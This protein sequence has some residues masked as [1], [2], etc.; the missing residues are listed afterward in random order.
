MLQPD[1]IA[2]FRASGCRILEQAPMKD[3]TTFHIGGPA[4]YFIT[5]PDEQAAGRVMAACR[6]QK[7]P[8][9]LVG[10]G[11]NLLVSDEGIDGVVL[12]L[13]G[14]S[15]P[16]DCDVASGRVTAYGGTSLAK[17]C[18]TARDYGLT[19][20]EFA[21]GIPGTVGGSVYMNAGAYGG[22]VAD[23]L[24]SATLLSPDGVLRTMK[25]EDLQ[26]GY[27]H[28]LLMETGEIAVGAV[29][30]LSPG[31]PEHIG[32]RM[33]ELMNKRREKQPLE[34]PSA[35]SFFKRPEGHFAAAL[36][37]QCRLK[38]FSVGDA[39]VSEKHAGFV[40]N[41]GEATCQDMIRLK[42]EVCRRVYEQTGVELK[43]EVELTGR[44]VR[45]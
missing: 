44:N 16:T 4:D 5:A 21:F 15:R 33:E 18:R 10:K 20:M 28:S 29:F 23:I 22:Q 34:Y 14:D 3:F 26:L 35:G 31:N 25:T 42:R 30:Q 13:D 39:Q 27:R 2:S 11:S 32:A 1:T 17:V 19:G 45:W 37:D 9:L 38:G 7:V 12:R 24:Y 41:R 6:Q 8:V 40:V 43:P 36:I